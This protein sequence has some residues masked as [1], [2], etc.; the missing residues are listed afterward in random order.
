MTIDQKKPDMDSLK[1]E[2]KSASG[3]K[4]VDILNKLARININESTV[5]DD[6]SIE[7]L[8][9]SRRLKYDEGRLES[10]YVIIGYNV[11]W[12]DFHTGQRYLQEGLNL[13]LNPKFQSNLG[14]W[15]ALAANV[16]NFAGKLELALN[17][18][19]K[20]AHFYDKT[21]DKL[22]LAKT[23]GSQAQIYM[24]LGELDWA[25]K[26]LNRHF[27]LFEKLGA[28]PQ[29]Y[30]IYHRSM[31]SLLFKM[32]EY[33]KSID[34]YMK[35]LIFDENNEIVGGNI[36][37]LMGIGECYIELNDYDSA[38]TY[39]LKALEVINEIPDSIENETHIDALTIISDV[40]IKTNEFDIAEKFLKKAEDIM[41]DSKNLSSKLPVYREFYKLYQSQ[42]KW[43]KAYRYH[44]L[45]S[46]VKETISV[47]SE[48]FGKMSHDINERMKELN[49]LYNVAQFT[50]DPA[51][52]R[53]EVLQK[54]TDMIPVS[55]QYPDITHARVSIKDEKYTT[56]TF[57]ESEWKQETLIYEKDERIGSIEVF[58]SDEMPE[59][60]VGPFMREE[61]DLLEGMARLLGN[62]LYRKTTEME[63]QNHHEH[64][65]ELVEDRTNALQ[66]EIEE[67]KQAET[68]ILESKNRNDAILRASSNGIITINSDGLVETFNPAAEKIFGYTTEEI[69][70]RNIKI[71][72]PHDIT[73]KHD[74]FLRAYLTTGVKKVIDQHL[75]V[76]AR[77]K[78]G[79]LF[80]LE[81][82]IS[83]VE[84]KNSKLFTAIVSDISD[85]KKA[86]EKLNKLSLAVEQTPTI[87]II[88]DNEGVIE[89]VNPY[90]S[91]VTGYSSEEVIGNTPRILNSGMHSKEF[92]MGLWST[93]KSGKVWNDEI[94]NKRK[95][96]TIY[97]ENST[98]A[99]IRG[100]SGQ[101]SHFVAVKENITERKRIKTEM[102]RSLEDLERF[103]SM[104]IGREEK[105]IELK[106]EIN[107]LLTQAGQEKK[108]T[109]VE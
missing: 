100:E 81:I 47:E 14:G 42:E 20:S 44:V 109:I 89:Y 70:G 57:K 10:L 85:R 19:L 39:L 41:G 29:A 66:N 2:L 28:P 16:Y 6:Y 4:R 53:S 108:Y 35:I 23:C 62:Y 69:S 71:L 95:D 98:V 76:T 55:W 43:K 18:S 91:E 80:P 107:N 101:I 37:A 61:Q 50:S 30:N 75:E 74:S 88:T 106:E 25:M 15:Y 33:Q 65:E 5:A 34:E 79:D 17:Y 8:E 31:G 11:R 105:M 90:F 99:P 63:L 51:L 49:C 56:K 59:A 103:S 46:D 96:G 58:Y 86:E 60:D 1:V 84:L 102:E 40:Y 21:G 87:I 72:T 92:F 67:R 13:M 94:A 36:L 45:Y 104:S 7:A 38:L 3:K 27:N 9:L 24:A 97:W 32:G 93:V 26:S 64:L 54:S 52:S 77:R 82:G 78:D 12:G 73:E 48:S 83:E 68:E 22:Q